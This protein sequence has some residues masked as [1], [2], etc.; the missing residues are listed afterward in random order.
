MA[1]WGGGGGGGKRMG[2]NL[3]LFENFV[4]VACVRAHFTQ[5]T[6]S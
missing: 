1:G 4:E 5:Y 3:G 6:L 2:S